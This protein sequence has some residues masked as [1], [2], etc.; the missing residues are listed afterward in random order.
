MAKIVQLLLDANANPSLD[1]QG[2]IPREIVDNVPNKNTIVEILETGEK[3]YSQKKAKD[4]N[5][6]IKEGGRYHLSQDSHKTQASLAVNRDNVTTVLGNGKG[7]LEALRVQAWDESKK[8]SN[9]NVQSKQ[10]SSNSITDESSNKYPSVKDRIEFFKSLQ[11]GN[12]VA[13]GLK[14]IEQQFNGQP[15]GQYDATCNDE[16]FFK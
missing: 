8:E 4:R 3:N 7:K 6:K 12:A 9:G 13:K 10:T 14:E 15:L 16:Q 5:I 11:E 1:N 2:L